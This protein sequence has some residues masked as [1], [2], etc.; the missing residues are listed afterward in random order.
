M[1]KLSILFL[2]ALA[3]CVA[4]PYFAAQEP[5]ANEHGEGAEAA[6][7]HEDTPLQTVFRWTNAIILFG[8]LIFMLRKPARAFF[9][10]RRQDITSGLRRAAET[11]TS[12]QARMS[13][14]EKRLS[15]LSAELNSLR[16]G[17]Q[18]ESGAERDKILAE[19]KREIDR[20]VEQ[21]RQEIERTARGIERQIKEDVA[22][23]VI[24]R[25]ENTLRTQMTEDDQKRVV[26]RFI[27]KL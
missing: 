4:T 16:A 18:K 17:A 5:A 3:L 26:L 24:K 22:D 13:E 6:A 10:S 20:V 8:G 25:A 23:L 27:K 21:S 9:E 7:E 2:F 1:K 11:E 15:S 12:A 14:I 19:A